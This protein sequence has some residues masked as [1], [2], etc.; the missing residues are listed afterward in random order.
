MVGRD[1]GELELMWLGWA[2]N[3]VGLERGSCFGSARHAGKMMGGSGQWTGSVLASWVKQDKSEPLIEKR[4][5]TVAEERGEMMRIHDMAQSREEMRCGLSTW[6]NLVRQSKQIR[7]FL[8]DLEKWLKL[9]NTAGWSGAFGHVE[10]R[11]S[12]PF[13]A[14]Q[15]SDGEEHEYE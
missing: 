15:S 8:N 4:N 2:R 10:R 13:V 12:T 9:M 6:R 11:I 5:L 1:R 3:R 7:R 14:V